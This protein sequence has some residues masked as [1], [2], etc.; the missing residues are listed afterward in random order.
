MAPGAGLDDGLDLSVLRAALAPWGVRIGARRIAPGDESAFPAE[1]GAPD[2]AASL[3]R[4]R[5][6]GAARLVARRLL[7][8]IGADV[9]APLPRGP[10][11]A[12][13]WPAGVVGSLAHDDVFA[14]AAI[15]LSVN[16]GGLGVDVEP[17][18]PLP[19]D[20]VDLVLDAEEK[21]QGADGVGGRV[22]F[23][24]KEA[25]YKAIHPLDATPLEY[26]D[27]AVRLDEG[28]A[29]LRDGHALKVFV[30]A[31]GRVV[32]VALTERPGERPIATPR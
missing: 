18:E 31:R 27:I 8:E 24:C 20:V 25:V 23:A 30:S 1:S 15:A 29:T 16:V 5:A 3:L 21:R 19:P 28:R 14:V 32:C 11:G 4:R 9:E 2:N 6:S 10:A 22:V 17:D 12:P 13:V 7:R 26:S